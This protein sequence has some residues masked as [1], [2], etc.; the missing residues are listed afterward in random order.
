MEEFEK[1][2]LKFFD[3]S[4]FKDI[5]NGSM[6]TLFAIQKIKT[7]DVYSVVLGTVDNYNEWVMGPTTVKTLQY[8]S[9]LYIEKD[10]IIEG[11][12]LDGIMI[13]YPIIEKEGIMNLIIHNSEFEISTSEFTGF[14]L[15]IRNLL[16]NE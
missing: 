3:I 4:H 7:H 9:E 12:N 13:E 8:L 14:Q 1:Y 16:E 2:N 11:V 10:Y 6:N 5:T 15:I